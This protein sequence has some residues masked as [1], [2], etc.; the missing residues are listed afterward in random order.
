MMFPENE[1]HIAQCLT[2]DEH[3]SK[4]E[5]KWKLTTLFSRECVCVCLSLSPQLQESRANKCFP[6]FSH[7]IPVLNNNNKIQQTIN[8]G[9]T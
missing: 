6:I 5:P 2:P 8:Q 9:K 3:S 1:T 4:C 7:Q